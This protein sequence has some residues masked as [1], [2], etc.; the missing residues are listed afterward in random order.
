M[1]A[2]TSGPWH[3]DFGDPDG[4]DA[5]VVYGIYA[6]NKRLVETDSGV[7]DLSLEDASLMAAA[8]DLYEACKAFVDAVA[9]HDGS[10]ASGMQTGCAWEIA[11]AAIA[12]AT[13]P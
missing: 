5:G 4:D 10:L 6:G 9:E 1:S 8:P 2:H 7:Y 3:I 12:K 11:R 13:Q